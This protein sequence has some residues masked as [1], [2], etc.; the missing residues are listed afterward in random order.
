MF[1]PSSGGDHMDDDSVS[2]SMVKCPWCAEEILAEAKKCKHCGE[3]LTD[4]RPVRKTQEEGKSASQ[5]ET[6][7]WISIV[8]QILELGALRD[9]GKMTTAE[10]EAARAPLLAALPKKAQST[11]GSATF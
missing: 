3:F 6:E 8:D 10:F 5:V 4:D 11:G 1:L 2:I 9:A 7:T